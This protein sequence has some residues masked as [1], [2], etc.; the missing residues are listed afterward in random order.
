MK[1]VIKALCRHSLYS[2]LVCA[3]ATC[4]CST[5]Q[6]LPIAPDVIIVRSV[7]TVHAQSNMEKVVGLTLFLCLI[8]RLVNQLISTEI[9]L[10][11]KR[12]LK[13]RDLILNTHSRSQGRRRRHR[14]VRVL[15]C[16]AHRRALRMQV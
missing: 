4:Y 7:F 10:I 1:D 3:P 5:V 12:R 2:R 11:R 9:R 14:Q 16:A 15:V 8:G 6:R 13:I